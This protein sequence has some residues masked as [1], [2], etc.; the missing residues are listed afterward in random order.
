[1]KKGKGGWTFSGY[2]EEE[3]LNWER[4]QELLS[5][6]ARSHPA[7]FCKSDGGGATQGDGNYTYKIQRCKSSWLD[8]ETLNCR[9]LEKSAREERAHR[10]EEEAWWAAGS[11]DGREEGRKGTVLIE[12]LFCTSPFEAGIACE[13]YNNPLTVCVTPFCSWGKRRWER[14]HLNW[15][16][17]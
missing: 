16:T 8:T 10:G 12:H 9:L 13:Y 11:E 5:H 14:L 6:R 7:V 4:F 1:M 3:G 15:P 17:V 2:I